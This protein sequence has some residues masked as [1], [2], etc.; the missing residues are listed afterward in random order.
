MEQEDYILREIE[1]I[2]RMLMM[3][4]G[5]LIPSRKSESVK[6][7][8]LVKEAESQLLDEAGFDLEHFIMLDE[9]EKESYIDNY[10][11]FNCAN[12]E[13]LADVLAAMAEKGE[14]P[15]YGQYLESALQLYHICNL[16]DHTYSFDREGK[17]SQINLLLSGG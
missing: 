9:K 11:G 2:G 6:T 15:R 4:L 17:I 3:L 10:H 14:K 16:L 12:I 5:K 8:R 13:L 7:E 1:K